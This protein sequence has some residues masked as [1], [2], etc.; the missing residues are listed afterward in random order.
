[1]ER[2]LWSVDGTKFPEEPE[3]SISAIQLPTSCEEEIIIVVN[4]D[5]VEYSTYTKRLYLYLCME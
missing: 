3:K 5:R 1:M 2:L 4:V